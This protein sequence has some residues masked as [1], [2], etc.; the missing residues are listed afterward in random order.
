MHPDNNDPDSDGDGDIDVLYAL[1][2]L[3]A[4]VG[5]VDVSL[6]GAP[7]KNRADGITI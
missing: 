5:R 4:D 6:T 1:R 3:K 2:D 7:A